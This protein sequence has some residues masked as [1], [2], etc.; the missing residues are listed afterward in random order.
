MAR[1]T[2]VDVR[3]FA[4]VGSPGAGKTTLIEALL[5]KSGAFSR[6][7][8]VAEGTSFVDFD[9]EEREKKHSLFL[10]CFHVVDHKREMNL[11][12]TPGYPDYIGEALAAIHVVETAV[13]VINAVHPVT[14]H[15][16]RLW[17][18][19]VDSGRGRM[20]VVTHAD[21]EGVDLDQVVERI[22]EAFGERCVP[23]NLPV[24]AGSKLS[25][26]I[27][28]FGEDHG[29]VPELHD[30]VKRSHELLVEA[31]VT[32]DDAAMEKYLAT[33]DAKLEEL[34]PLMKE[35]IARGT[36]TPILFCSATK[37]IG[38]EDILHFFADD[39][40]SPM[41][42]PFFTASK[43]QDPPQPV[44]PGQ[45]RAFSGKIFKTVVD[46]FVGRL[47]YLRVVSGEIKLDDHYLN[48]RSGKSEKMGH[49]LRPKGKESETL[50]YAQAG[51]IVLLPKA[52]TLETNDTLCAESDPLVFSRMAMPRPM[53]ALAIHAKNR[54][55]EQKMVTTLRKHVGEDPTL[56]LDRDAQTAELILRGV[57]S[58]HLQTVLHRLHVR[59]KLDVETKVP[60]V[61]LRETIIGHEI[62]GHH[63]HRKQTGG[64]G[65][66]GEVFLRITAN[67]RGKGFEFVDATHGGSVP[68]NF[69]PAIEKGIVDQMARGV[70]AGYPVVDVKV[71]VYDGK[72]HDVDSDEMS[73][74]IAGARAF[75]D[76]FE[77]AKPVILEPIVNIQIAAPNKFMGDV[78]SDLNGRRGRITGMD[79]V[80]DT[81]V[82]GAEVP[83]KEVQTYGQ[84]LRSLT[85]G[86][87]SYTFEFSHYDVAPHH[88]AQ[89]LIEAYK[90]ERAKELEE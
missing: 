87:G 88:V 81:Q 34:I 3:N 57:S 37:D 86:E 32:L 12:D 70:V 8:S 89:E 67:E 78:T 59:Y 36:L 9:P 73:F 40:P 21:S 75:R 66:F 24:G 16:R 51:D 85:H 68:R 61:P 56:H 17:Q 30:I 49:I 5:H 19:V 60:R 69:L 62:E 26:V 52:E 28:V 71:A 63:R 84:D 46:P 48:P 23:A 33:G 39:C 41:R 90:S 15:T 20:I 74:K 54:A 35:G 65:Q 27:D 42:G 25:R 53:V 58:L 80:G 2:P 82:I 4:F 6:K 64:R 47:S 22:H 38:V 45:R 31:L 79:A 18:N 44:N 14:F 11:I 7:G 43:G 72:S 76:A 1:Y 29:P 13:L 77:K 10:K 83:L 55:D 50:D